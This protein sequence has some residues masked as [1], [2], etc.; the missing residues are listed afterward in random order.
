[1][2]GPFIIIAKCEVLAKV[3]MVNFIMIEVGNE[4]TFQVFFRKIIDF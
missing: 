4:S 1:M 2:E 3:M